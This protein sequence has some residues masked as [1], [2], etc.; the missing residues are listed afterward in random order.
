MHTKPLVLQLILSSIPGGT[1][2]WKGPSETRN[3]TLKVLSSSTGRPRNIG[4]ERAKVSLQMAPDFARISE[5]CL[6]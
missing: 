6:Y 4:L 2:M 3:F 1:V 5:N